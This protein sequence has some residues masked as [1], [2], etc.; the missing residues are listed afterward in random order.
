MADQLA[1]ACD[2]G[3]RSIVS[4]DQWST[5]KAAG[6]SPCGMG[7]VLHPD[8]A[9][10]L[11]KA[12]QDAGLDFSTLHV[13]RGFETDDDM[14]VLAEAL[15]E[16]TAQT[17]FPLHVE[18]HRATMTQ[19][20]FRTRSLVQRFPELPITLDFS[21]WYTGHEMTYGEEFPERLS[22]LMPIWRSVRSLQLRIGDSCRMQTPLAQPSTAQSDYRQALTAWFTA[23]ASKLPDDA[24]LSC[25]PELL[26]FAFGEGPDRQVINYADEDEKHARFADAVALCDLV[27][28]I[29][30]EIS[31]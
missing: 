1:I 14:A 19:D 24:E 31:A 23:L 20:I 7:R 12:H 13:G 6:L 22:E 25:A 8:E 28:D 21:H 29:A 3:F 9:L 16:A 17:G 11:A 26:P 27:E 10:P 4:W 30:A 5:I 2:A 15:L 18:T